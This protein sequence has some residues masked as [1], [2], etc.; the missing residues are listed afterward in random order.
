MHTRAVHLHDVDACHCCHAAIA[1]SLRNVC[2]VPSFGDFFSPAK[3]F[4]SLCEFLLGSLVIFSLIDAPQRA[5][6]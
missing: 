2:C 1:I 5:R 4:F 6:L 3:L